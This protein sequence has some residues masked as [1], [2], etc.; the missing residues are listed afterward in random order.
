M[1]GNKTYIMTKTIPYDY[2]VPKGVV[3]GEVYIGS[4][5]L[6]ELEPKKTRVTYIS[7]ADPKGMIPGMIKS[8]VSKGQA[9]VPS[10]LLK[11]IKK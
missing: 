1:E 7:D 9:S 11:L 8:R 10:N 2:P 4:Y 5:C 3:R 6:E